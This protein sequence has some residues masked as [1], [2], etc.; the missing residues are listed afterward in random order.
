MRTGLS[1]DKEFS[2]ADSQ[3]ASFCNLRLSQS[4]VLR[5]MLPFVNRREEERS[6]LWVSGDVP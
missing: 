3:N 2:F 1:G 5:K 4:E 6:G